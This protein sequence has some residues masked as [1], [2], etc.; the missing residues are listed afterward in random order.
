[1]LKPYANLLYAL[2][3]ENSPMFNAVGAVIQALKD[4]SRE[5][6]KRMSM[7]TKGSI[8]WILLLQSCQFALGK[9]NLL[10]EFTTMHEDLCAKR[11]VILHS[12]MP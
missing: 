11:A 10:C 7:A 3:S 9:V 1:M 6:R 4:I 8:L 5:A 12:K 2:F